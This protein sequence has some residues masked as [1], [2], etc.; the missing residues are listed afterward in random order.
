MSEKE[1]YP[2]ISCKVVSF[3]DE[4][5]NEKPT[6]KSIENKPFKTR[7]PAGSHTV[8]TKI[9]VVILSFFCVITVITVIYSPLI[10]GYFYDKKT[11]TKLNIT[12][13]KIYDGY[14][15]VLQACILLLP[16]IVV[17]CVCNLL[18]GP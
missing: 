13:R 3:S 10:I 5:Q 12:L 7:R 17:V 2:L 6:I 1:E 4:D 15:D 8:T 9:I 16:F 14:V 18:H 11:N